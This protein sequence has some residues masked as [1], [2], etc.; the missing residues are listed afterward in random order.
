L[1]VEGIEKIKK[2]SETIEE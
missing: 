2:N 1:N